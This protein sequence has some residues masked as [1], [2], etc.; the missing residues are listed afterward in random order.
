MSLSTLT[1][2]GRVRGGAW[3]S[4]AYPWNVIGHTSQLHCPNLRLAICP[5]EGGTFV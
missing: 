3:G 5:V 2:Q 4:M 1:A